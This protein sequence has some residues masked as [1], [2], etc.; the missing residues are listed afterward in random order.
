MPENP[1]SASSRAVGI[2]FASGLLIVFAGLAGLGATA[3]SVAAASD[4]SAP[5]R[6]AERPVRV[7]EKSG[8][9]PAAGRPAAGK[10][11]GKSDTAAAKKE[12]RNSF[13]APLAG[14]DENSR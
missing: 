14:Y 6:P 13:A 11:F 5:A 8:N 4:E 10:S 3:I 1:H 2:L 9:A 7:P 12:K